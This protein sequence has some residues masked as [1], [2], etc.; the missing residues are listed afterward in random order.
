MGASASGQQTAQHGG[1]GPYG[2]VW[3][4]WCYRSHRSDGRTAAGC[5]SPV[6]MV[7]QPSPQPPSGHAPSGEGAAAD[8]SSE[9]DDDE[10]DEIPELLND[11][12][13]LGWLDAPA[14]PPAPMFGVPGVV[15]GMAQTGGQQ[16]G[17]P[18]AVMAPPGLTHPPIP[19]GPPMA[20]HYP[21]VLMAP[22]TGV[23]MPIIP[24]QPSQ[25]H[26]GAK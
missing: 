6:V 20:A 8:G 5:C 22:Y 24:G 1:D 18:P 14:P 17:A 19:G 9:V 16:Q 11:M 2:D 15:A 25:Q 26:G 12:R 10:R 13:A 3:R 4:T 23:P 7:P 21:V